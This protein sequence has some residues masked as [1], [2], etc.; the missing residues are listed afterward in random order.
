MRRALPSGRETRLGGRSEKIVTRFSEFGGAVVDAVEQGL[1]E[2]DAY[3]NGFARQVHIKRDDGNRV[4]DL[5]REARVG[6]DLVEIGSLGIGSPSSIIASRCSDNPSR[7]RSI[8]SATVAPP[9]T[10]P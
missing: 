5:L 4:A 6:F 9:A 1:V 10:Q 7:P 2:R 8:A 3:T